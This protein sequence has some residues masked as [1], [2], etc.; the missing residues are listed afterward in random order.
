[1]S[2]DNGAETPICYYIIWK[3]IHTI[4]LSN[5]SCVENIKI[6]RRTALI[7]HA[8]KVR[9]INKNFRPLFSNQQYGRHSAVGQI[10][11]KNDHEPKQY[12]LSGAR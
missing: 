11:V 4:G 12:Q 3:I 2:M 8:Q 1:M 6:L 5:M 9:V 7:D 10:S